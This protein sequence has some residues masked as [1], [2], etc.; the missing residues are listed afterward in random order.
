MLIFDI[1]LIIASYSEDAWYWMTQLNEEFRLYSRSDAGINEF[2]RLFWKKEPYSETSY[3]MTIFGLRHSFYDEPAYISHYHRH[4]WYKN[5]K[6][7]RDNDL[8]AVIEK[9]YSS[10]WYQNGKWH[11]ANDKSAVVFNTGAQHWFKNGL[12][13]RDNGMPAC[14]TTEYEDL[15]VN[16]VKISRKYLH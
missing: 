15:W 2:I 1:N 12:K 5:N 9:G 10:Q 11:R 6:L 3:L 13:H 16:G 8:P 7:H 14:I 4:E